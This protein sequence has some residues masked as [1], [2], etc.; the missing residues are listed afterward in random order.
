[1]SNLLPL[2]IRVNLEGW[3]LRASRD[4]HPSFALLKKKV[5]ARDNHSCRY[6]GYNGPD[7]TVVNVDGNYHDNKVDNLATACTLCCNCQFLGSYAQTVSDSVDKIL[8]LPE[9]AQGKLNQLIRVIFVD[10]AQQG[11]LAEQVQALYRALRSR[12]APVEEIFGQ[13]ASDA[14][15]F[16]QLSFDTEITQNANYHMV[17]QQL[18]LLPSRNTYQQL[19]PAWRSAVGD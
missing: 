15:V 14:N 13:R 18:R 12:A 19:I 2:T 5:L 4:N 11:D 3:S 6:C 7:I 16:A 17:M 1:V 10:S 9:I 8:F